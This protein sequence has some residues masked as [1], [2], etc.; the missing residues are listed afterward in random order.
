M[1]KK[2]NMALQAYAFL[3][4]IVNVAFFIY[5]NV[6]NEDVLRALPNSEMHVLCTATFTTVFAS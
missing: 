1:C 2:I 3:S 5:A 6:N 4:F